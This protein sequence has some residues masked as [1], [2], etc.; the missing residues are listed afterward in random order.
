MKI[1]FFGAGNM[2]GAILSAI[3]EKKAAQPDEVMVYDSRRE[4]TDHYAKKYDIRMADSAAEAAD[5]GEILIIAVKPNVVSPLISGLKAETELKGKVFVSI[6]AGVS[7]GTFSALV[8][9]SE[10]IVRT[11]PNMPALVGQ[12]I[13]GIFFHGFS[14][15]PE[16]AAVK[17]FVVKLFDSFGRSVIVPREDMID[18]MVAVTSSSPAYVC[19]M[20]EAMADQAV[21]YG[22]TRADALVMAEQAILGTAD[23]M[24]KEGVNPSV[25]KDR[26][27]SPGGTTIE[28]VTVLEEKG[29]RGTL[30][31][32]MDACTA[33][34]R[35]LGGKA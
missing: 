17:D 33:K 27:C 3:I 6:A 2:G 34:T 32:A 30:M 7:T 25:L 29:F 15:S 28:A 10:R 1:S 26:I 16:D 12:G 14:D 9:P 24:L 5:F 18:D 35:K 11:I 23:L 31:E 13:T 20:V 19:L 22:F 21:K 4:V 8:G